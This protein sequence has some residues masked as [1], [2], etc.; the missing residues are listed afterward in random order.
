MTYEGNRD[1]IDYKGVREVYS[2]PHSAYSPIPGGH[3]LLISHDKVSPIASKRSYL[4]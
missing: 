1:F 4:G 3:S 2:S